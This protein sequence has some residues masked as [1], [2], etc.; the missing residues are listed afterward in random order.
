MPRSSGKKRKQYKNNDLPMT[1]TDPMCRE[2]RQLSELLFMAEC[3]LAAV[4]T[5]PRCRQEILLDSIR[6]VVSQEEIIGRILPDPICK[7]DNQMIATDAKH[8][9][10]EMRIITINSRS[11]C[12]GGS[13]QEQ[14]CALHRLATRAGKWCFSAI[15]LDSGRSRR[16]ELQ[17]RCLWLNK[18][19]RNL[20]TPEDR[21]LI[22][23]WAEKGFHEVCVFWT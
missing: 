23:V 2:W 20:G 11:I 14:L 5:P 21:I 9:C 12:E 22:V 18:W 8:V 7:T 16:P 1:A 15:G 4:R 10:T 3:A 19:S 17:D 13:A 6:I